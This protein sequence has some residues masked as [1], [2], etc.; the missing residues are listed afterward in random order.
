[1]TSNYAI[2]KFAFSTFMTTEA[3]ILVAYV[4]FPESYAGGSISYW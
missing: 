1:M 4:L 3:N 2:S